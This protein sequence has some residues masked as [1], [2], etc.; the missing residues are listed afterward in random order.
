VSFRVL[1]RLELVVV[2]DVRDVDAVGFEVV[3]VA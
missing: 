3:D 1:S 2:S